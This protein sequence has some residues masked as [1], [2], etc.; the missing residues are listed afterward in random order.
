MYAVL[1]GDHFKRSNHI[2]MV[3]LVRHFKLVSQEPD[4]LLVAAIV[5][6]EDL[7]DKA[8]RRRRSPHLDRFPNLRCISRAICFVRRYEPQQFV[9]V[10]HN[11]RPSVLSS[12]LGVQ[13]Y[14]NR[15]RGESCRSWS[16]V[17]GHWSLVLV[18]GTGIGPPKNC[19]LVDARA[20]SV[21]SSF[22]GGIGP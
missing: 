5:A 11:Q 8:V 7:D 17:I 20:N 19:A 18:L 21:E 4:L 9:A 1:C 14:G 13:V 12:V 10:R 22:R 6:V 15:F 16:L 3:Q 2:G